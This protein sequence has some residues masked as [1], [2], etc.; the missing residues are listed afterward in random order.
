M[1]DPFKETSEVVPKRVML[2]KVVL[3]GVIFFLP[4]IR[5]QFFKRNKVLI[6]L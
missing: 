2:S 1:E 4:L 3:L 6:L 5:T